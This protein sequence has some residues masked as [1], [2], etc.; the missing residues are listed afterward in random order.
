MNPAQT[1]DEVIR[2]DIGAEKQGR[3]LA[4]PAFINSIKRSILAEDIHHHCSSVN[5]LFCLRIQQ[6]LLRLGALICISLL[7]GHVLLRNGGVVGAEFT[8][9]PPQVSRGAALFNRNTVA[10]MKGTAVHDHAHRTP[11]HQFHR[12]DHLGAPGHGPAG[13]RTHCGPAE[14]TQ[15]PVAAG[16]TT[17]GGETRNAT[18]QGSAR[19]PS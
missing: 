16:L 12:V 14:C 5:L 15:C 8:G 4:S 18:Q 19:R 6:P 2:A 17:A 9:Y 10:L 1:C 3:L 7:R 13:C 11:V